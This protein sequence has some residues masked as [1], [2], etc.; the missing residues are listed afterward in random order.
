MSYF[1]HTC[2]VLSVLTLA[3]NMLLSWRRSLG[4]S[5][6][7][8]WWSLGGRY[9]VDVSLWWTASLVI[10]FVFP[11]LCNNEWWTQGHIV[12][13]IIVLWWLCATFTINE[14]DVCVKLVPGNTYGIIRF[15]LKPGVTEVVSELSRLL[16]ANLSRN[17][18]SKD[19][20]SKTTCE[21][22]P[23]Y[24]S[25]IIHVLNCYLTLCCFKHRCPHQQD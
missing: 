3:I 23:C 22:F 9:S 15:G 25:F 1:P 8:W 17:R 10:L 6:G 11:L 12:I 7:G 18:H 5:R 13:I 14:V 20:F 4:L 19:I 24:F 21:N 16:D 2:W